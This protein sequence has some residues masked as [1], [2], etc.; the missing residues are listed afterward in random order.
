MAAVGMAHGRAGWPC[1]EAAAALLSLLLSGRH[2]RLVLV[3]TR[4]SPS[5]SSTNPAPALTPTRGET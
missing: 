1:S 4:N 2:S 5:P 3:K